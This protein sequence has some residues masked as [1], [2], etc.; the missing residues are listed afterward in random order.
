MNKRN[1]AV[2]V[3]TAVIKSQTICIAESHP[4]EKRTKINILEKNQ[5]HESY[6]PLVLFWQCPAFVECLISLYDYTPTN[7]TETNLPG[8]A[9]SEE[10]RARIHNLFTESANL[11][12]DVVIL[13]L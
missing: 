10:A 5:N 4:E 11:L 8:R 7:N 1:Q 12:P 3:E 9:L 13:A 6:K 2:F